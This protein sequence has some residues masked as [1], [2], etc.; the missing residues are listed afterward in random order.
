MAYY[1][2]LVAQW[3]SLTGTTAQKLT[4]INAMTVAGPYAPS[5]VL[6][7]MTYLRSNN[8]W[9]PIKAAVATSAGAAAAVDYNSDPR[10]ETLDATLPASQ[11]MLADLVAHALLTQAQALAIVALGVPQ[12][13][14]WQDNGYTGPFTAPDLLAAGGLT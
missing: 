14:W 11:G 13:P 10:V 3:P 9:M 5:P 7:V 4:A 12:L 6:D 1:D 8:L 2:A